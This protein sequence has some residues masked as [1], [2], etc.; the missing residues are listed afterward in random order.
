MGSVVQLKRKP[1]PLPTARRPSE[2]LE[3]RES[4]R[5]L[6]IL[7]GGFFFTAV[8]MCMAVV[9]AASST[10]TDVAVLSLFVIVFALLKIV[11]ANA[12]FWTMIRY[13]SDHEAVAAIARTGAVFRRP[14]MNLPRA[15]TAANGGIHRSGRGT[16]AGQRFSL[17][18]G[19]PAPLRPTR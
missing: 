14:A 19:K 8:V 2:E 7:M 6:L 4:T 13:D 5:S 3:Q 9:I 11:L 16:A 17:L 15:I 18:R 10:W 12:L 1:P